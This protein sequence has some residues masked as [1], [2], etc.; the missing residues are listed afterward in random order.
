MYPYHASVLKGFGKSFKQQVRLGGF[1]KV[2]ARPENRVVVD[3]NRKDAYGIPILVAHFRWGDNDRRVYRDMMKTAFEILDAARCRIIVPSPSEGFP[4][5]SG[6][7]AHEVGT[8]RMG[9]NPR[10]SV[11]N[12]YCQAHEVK[13][14]FALD[15]SVFTTYKEKNPVLN[16]RGPG[17]PDSTVYGRAGS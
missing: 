6:F 16:C 3:P 10:T 4:E 14:L 7:A 2:L 5:P 11:L 17:L 8:I 12:G 1:T 13:N 9:K 15:C